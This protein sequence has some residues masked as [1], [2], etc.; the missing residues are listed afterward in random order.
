MT[1]LEICQ[2]KYDAQEDPNYWLDEDEGKV[3]PEC[4]KK[5]EFYEV[6]FDYWYE[7]DCGHKIT[8]KGVENE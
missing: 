2:R 4:G 7:C 5:M 1:N 6:E 3:C 8:N